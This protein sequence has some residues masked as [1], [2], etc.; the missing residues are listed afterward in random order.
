MTLDAFEAAAAQSAASL[1]TLQDRL[2]ACFNSP[3]DATQMVQDTRE[4]FADT[5]LRSTPQPLPRSPDGP[6]DSR[7]VEQTRRL[8][9]RARRDR[10]NHGSRP[11]GLGLN[12]NR[13]RGLCV[14]MVENLP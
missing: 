6:S 13:T 1:D 5:S 7:R 14:I 11:D 10:C 3:S 2:T 9:D 4:A 8:Y 12:H